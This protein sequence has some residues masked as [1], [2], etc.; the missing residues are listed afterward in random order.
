[1]KTKNG[2]CNFLAQAGTI[3][4][5]ALLL[6]PP[7]G[8]PQVTDDPAALVNPFVGSGLSQIH[9]YEIGRASCRERVLRLV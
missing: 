3:S 2:R 7:A 5:F 9:D 8:F 4:G 1:M 6:L